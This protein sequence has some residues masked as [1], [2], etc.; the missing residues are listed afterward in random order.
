M[1]GGRDCCSWQGDHPRS[2]RRVEIRHRT[3]EAWCGRRGG[4]VGDWRR[5][6]LI[7]IPC[8]FTCIFKEAR[9]S[10]CGIKAAWRARM[11]GGK[12]CGLQQVEGASEFFLGILFVHEATTRRRRVSELLKHI[13]SRISILQLR[14]PRHYFTDI[15]IRTITIIEGRIASHLHTR[16]PKSPTRHQKRHLFLA[17]QVIWDGAPKV[18]NATS[19]VQI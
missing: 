11:A 16:V 2:R 9:W 12:S 4:S 3:R 1:E 18:G 7:D 10:I 8:E 13:S 14:P 15:T 5:G 17:R 19:I 6:V